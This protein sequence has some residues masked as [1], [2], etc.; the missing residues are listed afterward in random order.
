[1]KKLI[2]WLR[3]VGVWYLFLGVMNAA[4]VFFNP[5]VAAAGFFPPTYSPDGRTIQAVNDAYLPSVFAF[6]VLGILMLY[7]SREP[8]RGRIVVL[9][10]ALLEL[11]AWIVTDLVWA[12]HAFALEFVIP[13]FTIHLV[14]GVTGLWFVWQTRPAR[15]KANESVASHA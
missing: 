12:A 14:I 7:F 5:L 4:F 3:I 2:W 9:I 1:M 15:V 11:G 10:V 6:L 13:F 8:E